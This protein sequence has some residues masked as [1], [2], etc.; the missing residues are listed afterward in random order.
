VQVVRLAVSVVVGGVVGG[1]V[2]AGC[3][4]SEQASGTLPSATAVS[5]SPSSSLPPLGPADLPMPA[6]ARQQTPKAAATFIAY[7]LQLINRTNRDMDAQYLR[8]LSR[9]CDTCDRIADETDQDRASNYHYQGGE[10]AINGELDASITSAGKAESAF[11][12]RQAELQVL[13]IAGSPVPELEFA[14][15]ENMSSGASV[16]WDD[17][18]TSWRI[19]ELTLG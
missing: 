2:L 4:S 10:L 15:I 3:S 19:T 14:A 5:A 18:S 7:Y 17:Q 6:E 8:Q 1:V 13:D 9:S 16:I 12:L 11:T